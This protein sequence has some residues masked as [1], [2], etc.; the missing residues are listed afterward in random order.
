MRRWSYALL[1]LILALG[2]P[3]QGQQV[4]FI[5]TRL[6]L[7]AHPLF[8]QF[9]A[10]TGRFAGT[11][12]EPVS[13]GEEGIRRVQAEL[14]AKRQEQAALPAAWAK[15]FSAKLSREERTAAEEAFLAEQR[16]LQDRIKVLEERLVQLRGVHGRPGLTSN[17]SMVG[18][19]K[20]I[21]N[22]L[23]AVISRLR[24]GS[25]GA[26]IDI[27]PLLPDRPAAPDTRIVYTNLN[28]Q[29]WR[30]PFQADDKT[31]AWLEHA[32]RFLG[33]WHQPLL[34]VV[35]GGADARLEAV[36]HLEQITGGK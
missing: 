15:R 9:S 5:D 21:A 10:D 31:V 12:S 18:Q 28:F 32:K 17:V 35:Y 27:S 2:V 11:P 20:T 3:A 16:K 23:R 36:K 25:G 19:A 29:L 8:R 22:D 4:K 13:D 33:T 14:E 7:L 30:G 34:P 24:S 1:L 26:V 6:L